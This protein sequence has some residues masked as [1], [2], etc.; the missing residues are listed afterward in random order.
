MKKIF[1]ILCVGL[2][3]LGTTSAQTSI[4]A[5]INMANFSGDDWGFDSDM[6]MGIR[7]GILGKLPLSEYVSVRGGVL[8]S[9]KGYEVSD[10]YDPLGSGYYIDMIGTLSYIESPLG[11][12]F[13]ANDMIFFHAGIYSGFLIS[14]RNEMTGYLD[15]TSKDGVS[16]VDMG[17][18]LGLTFLVSDAISINAGY[19]HGFIGAIEDTD[20]MNSSIIIGMGYTFG[21][22]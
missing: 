22:Y 1:A 18:D 9:V 19:Q 7:V 6:K 3:T 5:G 17:L 11:F 13:S 15:N 21:G 10:T 2:F 4:V 14:V 8:Y 16:S 12:E 20:I